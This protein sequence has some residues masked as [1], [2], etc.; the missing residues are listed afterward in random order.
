MALEKA[1]ELRI[2]MYLCMYGIGYGHRL[3]SLL[4]A[5]HLYFDPHAANSRLLQREGLGGFFR[6]VSGK[7][8]EEK[9]K[10]R[11]KNRSS[12]VPNRRQ[13][14]PGGVGELNFKPRSSDDSAQTPPPAPN[15][16]QKNSN[17]PDKG[18]GKPPPADDDNQTLTFKPPGVPSMAD[19]DDYADFVL[20]VKCLD[21]GKTEQVGFRIAMSAGS[22]L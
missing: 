5:S 17:K 1:A 18:K 21:T 13:T 7:T 22:E 20:E 15:Y 3:A 8:K 2:A 16:A 11:R 14:S 10:E 12:S 19:E 6:A 4:A 9:I